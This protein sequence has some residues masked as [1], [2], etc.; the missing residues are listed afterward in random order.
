MLDNIL[1]NV[2]KRAFGNESNNHVITCRYTTHVSVTGLIPHG[3]PSRLFSSYIKRL[4]YKDAGI[5]YIEDNYA[6]TCGI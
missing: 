4:S 3:Y 5:S 6:M 1:G 2:I